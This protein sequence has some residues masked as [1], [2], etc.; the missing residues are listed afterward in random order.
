V[1]QEGDPTPKVGSN[2]TTTTLPRTDGGLG[3]GV[4]AIILLGGLVAFFAYQYMGK[5]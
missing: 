1:L 2:A 3:L 5:S 4:Y